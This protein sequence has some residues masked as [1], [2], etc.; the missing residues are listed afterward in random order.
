VGPR[1]TRGVCHE[2]FDHTALIKTILT[3]FAANPEQAI[4]R[5]GTRVQNAPHLGNVLEDAP[6]DDIAPHTEVR[7]ALDRW[8]TAAAASR[9]ASPG[10][11]ASPAPDGAGRPLR[12]HDFQEEFA[13]FALPMREVLPPSQP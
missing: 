5:M 3:R 13:R 12:L 11:T 6:R 10:A 4:A 2:T 1:V 9:Y 8:R 7:A